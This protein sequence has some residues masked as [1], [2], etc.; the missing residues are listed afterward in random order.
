LLSSRD[1]LTEQRKRELKRMLL[2]GYIAYKVNQIQKQLLL[3]SES[4]QRTADTLNRWL[5]N[6]VDKIDPDRCCTHDGHENYC[7][8]CMNE[9]EKCRIED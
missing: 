4:D 3:P 7:V 2:L 9:H 5:N 6:L 8:C 1:Q